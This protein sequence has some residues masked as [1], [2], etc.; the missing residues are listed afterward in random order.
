MVLVDLYS[1]WFEIDRL[2]DMA[3]TTVIRKLK[4]HFSVH[5]SPH[6]PLSDN[7]TQYISQR[8]K[9][10]AS[11]WDFVHVTSSPEFPQANGLAEKAV[12]SAKKLLEK[13][14]RDQT[15]IFRNI[16]NIRN[17]A[18][19]ATLGSPAKRLM[20]RQTRTTFPISKILLTP[21]IKANDTVKTQLLKKRQYQKLWYD[22]TSHHLR[23]RLNV[24]MSA[25]QQ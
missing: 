23:C 24:V 14:K 6:L 19:D 25:W 13:S 1:G 18:R 20:S 3:S 22:K 16:L 4:R 10:F 15:D 5:G 21:D 9:D 12:G 2:R 11:T 8:F 17:I 7:G